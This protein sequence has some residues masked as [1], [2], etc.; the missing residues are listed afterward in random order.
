VEPEFRFDV[1]GST[2]M[3]KDDGFSWRLL[4]RGVPISIPLPIW[5]FGGLN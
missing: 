3:A 2:V 1:I 5:V 4:L